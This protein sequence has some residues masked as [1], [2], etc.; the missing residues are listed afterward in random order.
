MSD[1]NVENEIIAK[2]LIAPR[3]TP[4]EIE[5][6]IVDEEYVV[7]ASSTFTVCCLTLTNGFNVSGESA[8]ASPANYDKE[9]GEQIARRNA[10][11][12]I[13]ALE[14]YLLKQKL[15]ENGYDNA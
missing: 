2:G 10:V 1:L 12:K 11:S 5:A 15:H 13:W 14:G 7:F 6:T 8:C 3:L 9:L 4:A